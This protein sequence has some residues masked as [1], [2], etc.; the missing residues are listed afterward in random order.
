[1][2]RDK[3]ASAVTTHGTLFGVGVGPGDPQLLT[4]KACEVIRCA[5]VL[6]YPVNGSG[7]SFARAIASSVIPQG[8]TELPIP[9]PMKVE[10]APARAAYDAAA[11]TISDHLNAGR[12]V[13]YLCAG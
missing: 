10:R 5:D 3:G 11:T 9:I 2:A 6:A 4:L 8:A 13:A 1:M 7:I 12:S